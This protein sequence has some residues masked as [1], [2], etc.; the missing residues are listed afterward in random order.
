ML[1]KLSEWLSRAASFLA[2][3]I[4]IAITAYTLVEIVSRTLFGLSSNVLVE[5]VGYGLAAMTFLAAGRTMRDGHLVRVNVVLQFCSPVARRALDAFCLVCAIAVVCLIAYYVWLDMQR[6]FTRGYET[7][8]LVPL[9][10][11]LP[12]LALFIGMVTFIFDMLVHLALVLA[13]RVRLADDA[14][15]A[16]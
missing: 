13:G 11:W 7:D 6:S 3:L 5:F 9:P 1:A 15:D 12:P 2:G 14:P 4:L 8:S 10:M 16:V